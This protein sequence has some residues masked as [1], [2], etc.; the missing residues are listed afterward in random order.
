[1]RRWLP[2]LAAVLLA[3]ACAKDDTLVRGEQDMACVVDGRLLT[4]NGMTFIV[5]EE[6]P[7]GAGW[8]EWDRAVIVCDVLRQ[9]SEKE[10]EIRLSE[11]RR[12]LLKDA[13]EDGELSEEE[14]GDD[15]ADVVYGWV[16]G[17]YLNLLTQITYDPASDRKHLIHLVFLGEDENGLRF[18]LRHNASGYAY[19]APG[20]TPPLTLGR[21]YVSFPVTRFLPEGADA[22]AFS[23]T[24]KWHRTDAAGNL[25]PETQEQSRRGI[26]R[27]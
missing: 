23:L 7:G 6:E 21:S 2:C 4:D 15:P 13:V 17:G 11:A 5:T 19:G 25:L 9:R 10:F 3:A 12:V 14:L 8:R 24:W 26:I 16:S 20:V 22:A 1:M 27:R 18:R